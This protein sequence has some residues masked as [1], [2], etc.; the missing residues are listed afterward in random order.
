APVAGKQMEG[1]HRP[2]VLQS[3]A[4]AE[5]T[6]KVGL[7]GLSGSFSQKAIHQ[8]FGVDT[9]T[10]SYETFEELFAGVQKGEVSYAMVPVENSLTGSIHVNYD[11]LLEHE[12]LTIVGEL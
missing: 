6:S 5:G 7:Q 3:T 9:P 4:P 8:Y 2:I 10:E 1:L 12:E 11:L